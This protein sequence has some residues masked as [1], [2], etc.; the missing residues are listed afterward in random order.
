MKFQHYR[1]KTVEGV[2]GKRKS[3]QTDG[4]RGAYHNMTVF[5]NEQNMW[6]HNFPHTKSVGTPKGNNSAMENRIWL[7]FEPVPFLCLLLFPASLKQSD[8]K[9]QRK[10]GDTIF[11]NISPWELLV[12]VVPKLWSDTPQHLPNDS[13]QKFDQD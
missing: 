13:T 8:Q 3:L 4:C 9:W 1:L 10:P 2:I 6:R 12:A 5:Q 11:P 7:N